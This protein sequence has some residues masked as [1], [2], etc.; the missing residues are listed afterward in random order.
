MFDNFRPNNE[1]VKIELIDGFDRNI[2]LAA[3][4]KL[5]TDE[6]MSKIY[7]NPDRTASERDIDR[8][9]IKLRN[10]KNTKRLQSNDS[11]KDTYY[12]G[13]RSG[14]I[15]RIPCDTTFNMNSRS[16]PN[17]STIDNTNEISEIQGQKISPEPNLSQNCQVENMIEESI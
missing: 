15:Q 9:L 5:K 6:N 13:I 4:K 2:V 10:E 12:F 1:T 11:D 3:S 17:S 16:I 8:E 7:I 14:S